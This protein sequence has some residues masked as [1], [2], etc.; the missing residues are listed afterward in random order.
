M[1]QN[2]A[3][4]ISRHEYGGYE[5]KYI[6]DNIGAVCAKYFRYP[7]FGETWMLA[8]CVDSASL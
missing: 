7:K 3:T 8:Y 5:E 1:E 6:F 2:G 4:F